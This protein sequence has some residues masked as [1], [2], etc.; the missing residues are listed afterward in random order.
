[1]LHSVHSPA[2]PENL[3]LPSLLLAHG[4]SHL[5]Q[6]GQ[7]R[8]TNSYGQDQDP[9]ASNIQLGPM[10]APRLGIP[11]ALVFKSVEEGGWTYERFSEH[12]KPYGHQ[13]MSSTHLP[14]R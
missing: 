12:T 7:F 4:I 3:T 11:C 10:P 9:M 8:G 14:G 1:M 2:Y 6:A 13:A 5:Q